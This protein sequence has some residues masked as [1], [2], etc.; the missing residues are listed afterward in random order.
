MNSEL[1]IKMNKA[2]ILIFS[3]LFFTSCVSVND[4][5]RWD[6]KELKVVSPNLKEI[7]SEEILINPFPDMGIYEFIGKRLEEKS[8]ENKREI[9]H[10]QWVKGDYFYDIFLYQK[11]DKKWYVLDAIKWHK[12][13]KF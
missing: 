10:I 5:R 4:L 13:T 7:L 3:S 9:K 11:N 2:I 8:V 12:N 1:N 6:D